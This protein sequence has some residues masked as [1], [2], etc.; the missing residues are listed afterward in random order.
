MGDSVISYRAN[1]G[2]VQEPFKNFEKS[3]WTLN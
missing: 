2:S 1:S 3:K